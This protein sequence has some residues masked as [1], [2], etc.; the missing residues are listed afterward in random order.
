MPRTTVLIGTYTQDP[1]HAPEFDVSPSGAEGIY[2]A[3]FDPETGEL[4]DVTLAAEA[5]ISPSWLRAHPTLPVI[6]STNETMDGGGEDCTPSYMSAYRVGPGCTLALLGRVGTGGGSA[7]HFSIHPTAGFLAVA[8]HGLLIGDTSGAPSGG[9]AVIALDPATGELQRRTDLVTHPNAPSDPA[10]LTHPDRSDW[11][12]HTHSCNWSKS[13]R[14]LF[15]CEKGTDRVL[16]YAFDASDGTVSLA[17]GHDVTIG[18]GARHL[19]VHDSGRFIY[20]NEE[21]N[22]GRIWVFGFDDETGE[23]TELQVDESIKVR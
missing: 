1:T 22:Q 5:A 11:T 20:V 19:A 23:L 6:Y 16:V 8:N 10:L 9:L 13:G 21:S 14:W 15:A 17:A 12:S 3:T 18:G 4:S 2:R 7:C